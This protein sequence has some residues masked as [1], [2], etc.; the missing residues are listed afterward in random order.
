[1]KEK[2]ILQSKADWNRCWL[3]MELR[4]DFTLKYCE[5][6]HVFDGVARRKK[7][8]AEG[9]T[10]RLC[11]EHHREGPE[12]VHRNRKTMLII[13]RAAQRAY[14]QDHTRQQ[15]MELMHKNYLEAEGDDGR[16]GAHDA[17]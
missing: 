6:H 12:A 10:V 2:S 4:D 8:E 13:Q 3:C 14:E 5:T 17:G 11:I 9:L 7:S 1:M 16:M 15:W